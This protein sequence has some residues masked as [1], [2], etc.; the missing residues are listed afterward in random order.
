MRIKGIA[1]TTG[2]DNEGLLRSEYHE[3]AHDFFEKVAVTGK[4]NSL[5]PKLNLPVREYAVCKY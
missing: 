5:K 3:A 1:P 2:V 4:P